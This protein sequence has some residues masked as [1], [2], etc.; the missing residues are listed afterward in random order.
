LRSLGHLEHL[1]QRFSNL[2][3]LTASIF[4]RSYPQVLALK[5]FSLNLKDL[6]DLERAKNPLL[7]TG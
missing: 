2:S 6:K 7:S 3:N 4:D 5:D 1:E